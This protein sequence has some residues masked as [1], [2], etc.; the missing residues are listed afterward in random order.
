MFKLINL[1]YLIIIVL[2]ASLFVYS[3]FE[4]EKKTIYV[5]V[6]GYSAPFCITNDIGELRGYN[7]DLMNSIAH[8]LNI[9][10]EYRII[11]F[12]ALQECLRLGTVDAV[13]APFDSN[14]RQN[15]KYTSFTEPYYKNYLSYVVKETNRHF[16][17]TNDGVEGKN[18]CVVEK[19]RILEYVRKYLYKA[20]LSI[21]SSSQASFKGLFEGF[22]DAVVDTKSS[23]EYYI[24]KHKLRRLDV[25]KHSGKYS[26]GRTYRIAVKKGNDN[27]VSDLNKGLLYVKQTGEFDKINR[28]W[29]SSVQDKY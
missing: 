3:N 2:I 7:I 24:T 22:C 21:Y 23:N 6:D 8:A 5:G 10:V 20:R 17:L 27:L 13:I 1:V 28:K 25:K 29:F 26:P 11:P 19:Q 12:T 14:K 4:H 9:K 16:N 15:Q 18:I